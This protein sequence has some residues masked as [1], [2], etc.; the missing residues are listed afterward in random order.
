LKANVVDLA[1][2]AITVS[3][4]D[5]AVAFTRVRGDM[6]STPTVSLR[7]CLWRNIPRSFV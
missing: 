4:F 6:L 3:D 2:A 7:G 5:Q 1:G